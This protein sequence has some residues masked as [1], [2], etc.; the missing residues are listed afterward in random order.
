MIIGG[1][2]EVDSKMG[3]MNSKLGI[4]GMMTAMREHDF[5]LPGNGLSVG[6]AL[7]SPLIWGESLE[8][9]HV[10]F[11]KVRKLV[12]YKYPDWLILWLNYNHAAI[13]LHFI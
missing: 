1:L 4:V 9:K 2:S 7:L 11:L 3:I 5:I 13:H 10:S 6:N 8:N 12:K